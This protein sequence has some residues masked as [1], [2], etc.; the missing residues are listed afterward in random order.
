MQRF[1]GC[2]PEGTARRSDISQRRLTLEEVERDHILR[3]F[4][5]TGGVGGTTASRLR[6]PRKTLNAMM[7]RLDISR[8]ALLPE[9]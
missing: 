2:V 3:F 9:K 8:S 1:R 7:E 4:G 5:E 6:I